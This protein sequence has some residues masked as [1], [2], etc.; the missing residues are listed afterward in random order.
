[1]LKHEDDS[2]QQLSISLTCFFCCC[3]LGKSLA[4]P[5]RSTR[6]SARSFF[7][8]VPCNHLFALESSEADQ[9]DWGSMIPP[10]CRFFE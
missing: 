4:L 3:L 8:F 5:C 9:I 6:S 7:A 10:S 2:L 1:M